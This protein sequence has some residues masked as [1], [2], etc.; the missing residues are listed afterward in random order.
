MVMLID[1][2]IHHHLQTYPHITLRVGHAQY[3]QIQPEASIW[4]EIWGHGFRF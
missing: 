1:L 4:F 3:W 2:Q